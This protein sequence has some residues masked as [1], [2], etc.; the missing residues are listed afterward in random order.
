MVLRHVQ[1]MVVMNT[2]RAKPWKAMCA[3]VGN[4]GKSRG[5]LREIP[6]ENGGKIPLETAGKSCW[7]PRETKLAFVGLFVRV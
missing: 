1:A 2:S 5:K 3:A 4:R 7:K 6:L